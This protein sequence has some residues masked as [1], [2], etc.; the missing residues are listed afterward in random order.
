LGEKTSFK[1]TEKARR[2]FRGVKKLNVLRKLRN[3]TKSMEEVK[4]WYRNYP[5]SPKTFP[6]WLAG[7][8]RIFKKVSEKLEK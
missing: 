2:A 1:I 8:T 5:T 7:T 3:A 4:A 6:Q